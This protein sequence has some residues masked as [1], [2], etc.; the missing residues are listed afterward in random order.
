MVFYLTNVTNAVNLSQ[1]SVFIGGGLHAPIHI[2]LG[3]RL[4]PSHFDP[5][6]AIL[7]IAISVG[8]NQ[9]MVMMGPS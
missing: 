3:L 7:K 6:V 2:F 4:H 1:P 9:A 8:K 5:F